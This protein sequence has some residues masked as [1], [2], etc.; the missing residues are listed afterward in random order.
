MLW[1]SFEASIDTKIS[2]RLAGN[3]FDG[4]WKVFRCCQIFLY[5]KMDLKFTN[6]FVNTRSGQDWL[7]KVCAGQNGS[8]LAEQVLAGQDE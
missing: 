4:F 6:C 5:S 1:L 2:E 3:C 7:E 8:G